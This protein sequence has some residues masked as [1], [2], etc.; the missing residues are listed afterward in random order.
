MS[1]RAATRPFSSAVWLALWGSLSSLTHCGNGGDVYLGRAVTPAS[2]TGGGGGSS[3]G[4]G[5]CGAKPC[6]DNEGNQDFTDPSA[7][8]TDAKGKFAGA[9]DGS[10]PAR[11][12]TILYPSHETMFP[13]NV[14]TC[15]PSGRQRQKTRCSS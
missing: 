14:G 5:L 6:A 13:I 1:S 2:G 10:D 11:Q 15:E 9:V 12:P 4:S 8:D 7:A 3:T